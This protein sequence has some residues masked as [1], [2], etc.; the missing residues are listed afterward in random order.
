MSAK[1]N[2]KNE[3]LKYRIYITDTLKVISENTAKL[4]G[5]S[6]INIRYADIINGTLPKKDER[7]G[8]EI[9]EDFIAKFNLKVGGEN[10]GLA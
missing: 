10:S 5:G 3:E 6:Y 9:V 7:T 8:D 2:A 4:A 1:V